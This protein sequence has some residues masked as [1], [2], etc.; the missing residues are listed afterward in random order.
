MRQ[1]ASPFCKATDDFVRSVADA[2]RPHRWP[3]T[4][5]SSQGWILQ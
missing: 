1:R 3:G 2:G 5:I 4:I